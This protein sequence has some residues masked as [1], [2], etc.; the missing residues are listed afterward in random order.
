MFHAADR[1]TRDMRVRRKEPGV[2]SSAVVAP[3]RM[4]QQ[5]SGAMGPPR[6]DAL[7]SMVAAMV[8]PSL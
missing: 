3:D 4:I 2:P 6:R 7:P 5:Q 8:S 1:C